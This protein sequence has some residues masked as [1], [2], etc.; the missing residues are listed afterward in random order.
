M[1]R[2]RRVPFLLLLPPLDADAL[3]MLLH[4]LPAPDTIP[5]RRR[6]GLVVHPKNMKRKGKSDSKIHSSL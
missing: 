6:E 2:M 4:H 5:G 1:E 3:T